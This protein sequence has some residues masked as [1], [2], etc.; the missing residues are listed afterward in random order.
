MEHFKLSAKNW[1]KVCMFSQCLGD[2]KRKWIKK[3]EKELDGLL[4]FFIKE[5]CFQLCFDKKE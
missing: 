1:K 4:N 2:T 5:K 3:I